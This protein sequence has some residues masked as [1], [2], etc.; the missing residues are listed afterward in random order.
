M[1]F[2]S[3]VLLQS[4]Y[5]VFF[6]YSYFKSV[7]VRLVLKIFTSSSFCVIIHGPIL[8]IGHGYFLTSLCS[9]F[10][11]F[12]YC[13]G[14][15]GNP[16]YW[17]VTFHLVNPSCFIWG[18][19]IKIGFL[20]NISNL[21]SPVTDNKITLRALIHEVVF[22]FCFYHK[23]SVMFAFPFSDY[24]YQVLSQKFHSEE[25]AAIF[26]SVRNYVYFKLSFSSRS[27]IISCFFSYSGNSKPWTM[28]L[29]SS[30]SR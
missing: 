5:W 7:N 17:H 30:A 29:K 10:S 23:A 24:E 21:I 6:I 16:I 2:T 25:F 3:K 8:V 20:A 26:I 27:I 11:V 4:E 19:L 22:S 15:Q 12:I 18:Q 14:N 9:Y 13:T 28:D 1:R